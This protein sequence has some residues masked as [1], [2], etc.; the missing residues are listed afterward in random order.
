M[1]K[2]EED[3]IAEHGEDNITVYSSKVISGNLIARAPCKQI[4]GVSMSMLYL[5]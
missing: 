3:A 5:F 1:G 4:T 2:T